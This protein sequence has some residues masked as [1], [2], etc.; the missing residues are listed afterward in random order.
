MQAKARPLLLLLF[1]HIAAIGGTTD[2]S[3]PQCIFRVSSLSQELLPLDHVV[4]TSLAV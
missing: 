4:R 1:S 2:R 3:I